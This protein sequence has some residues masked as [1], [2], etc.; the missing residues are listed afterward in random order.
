ME[1]RFDASFLELP[2]EVLATSLR[3]PPERVDRRT[4]HGDPGGHSFCPYFLT[5][6]DRP[7]DMSGRTRSGNEWVVPPASRTP[8]S[9]RA[10]TGKAGSPSAPGSSSG[11]TSRRAGRA[12]GQ[13]RSGSW[14]WPAAICDQL[15]WAA[16][17][18]GRGRAA[19]A[20]GGPRDRDGQ[21]VHRSCRGSWAASTPA[22]RG[23]RKRSGRRSTSSTCRPR[24]RTAF[25]AAGSDRSPG[26]ADRWTRWSGIFGLGLIPTGSRDPFGLRRAAQGAVR[27]ALEGGLPLDLEEAR[28]E[29]AASSTATA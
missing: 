25:P 5:V 8:A 27:I 4:S 11:S 12:S 23:S 14:P 29:A 16:D 28:P 6:M 15:G 20:Q 22:R 24:R 2:A 18:G 19:P 9:S 13:D 26:L 3:R 17:R 7:D 21:G 10:R 1:G